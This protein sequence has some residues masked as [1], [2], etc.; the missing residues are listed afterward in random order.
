MYTILH[1]NCQINIFIVSSESLHNVFCSTVTVLLAV[2][3]CMFPPVITNLPCENFQLYRN[4]QCQKSYGKTTYEGWTLRHTNSRELDKPIIRCISIHFHQFL[5]N[6]YFPTQF[7]C[8]VTSYSSCNIPQSPE[9][10]LLGLNI[11]VCKSAWSS[12]VNPPLLFS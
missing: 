4:H 2:A 8:L 6:V 5:Q 7:T 11:Y 9:G 12:Q 3:N 10:P 1:Y